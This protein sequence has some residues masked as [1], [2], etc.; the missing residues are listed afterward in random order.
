LGMPGMDGYSVARQLKTESPSTPVILL[1]GWGMFL[2]ADDP[3]S[4]TVDLIL[5]KPP[6]V[7][8]LQSGLNAVLQ[9]KSQSSDSATPPQ[10]DRRL[11]P[12]FV[13]P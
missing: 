3:V 6:A 2:G 10:S 9:R 5:P 7:N 1:T 8:D 13:H 11:V 12:R 4:S